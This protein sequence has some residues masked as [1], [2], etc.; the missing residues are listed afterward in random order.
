MNS[1]YTVG[2]VPLGLAV[3]CSVPTV[4]WAQNIPPQIPDIKP[5]DP[6]QDEQVPDFTPIPKVPIEVVPPDPPEQQLILPQT[7]IVERFEIV[8]NSV[9][10]TEEIL[11]VLQEFVGVSLTNEDLRA[12]ESKVGQLYADKGFITSFAYLRLADNQELDLDGAIVTLTVAEGTIEQI[13]VS[14]KRLNR[15]IKRRLKADVKGVVKEDELQ[16]SLRWLLNDPRIKTISVTVNPGSEYGLAILNADVTLENPINVAVGLNNFRSPSVGT[17]ERQLQFQHLNV[18]GLGDTFSLGYRNTDG[19]NAVRVGYTVPLNSNDGTLGIDYQFVDSSIIEEPFDVLD[20]DGQSNFVQ[21]T[22]RQPIYRKA[23]ADKI[24]EVAVGA[25]LSHEDSQLRS[26]LFSGP[27]SRGAE[28]DGSTRITS[29]RFFQEW[30]KRQRKSAFGLRSQ[31]SL[32]L[33]LAS[34]DNAQA[35]D[36]QYFKWQGG[37]RWSRKLPHGLIFVTR[38]DLQFS[39]RPLLASEQFSLGGQSTIRGYRQNALLSDNG[40]L[41]TIALEIPVLKGKAGRLTLYPF[42]DVGTVWNNSQ[43]LIPTPNTLASA[44]VGVRYQLSDRLRATVELGIPLIN[45]PERLNT[46]Q[47]QG[48]YLSL[49]WN[50]F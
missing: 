25:T 4:A 11:D 22:Y 32:G 27:I 24:E 35:P 34:T 44:G 20:I 21:L 45:R 2:L 6:R 28:A 8:G 17:F 36:G 40:F 1:I 9:I 31:F 50:A 48:I 49:V 16:S 18:F 3:I 41:A 42:F 23:T 39:D 29:L 19:S 7:L 33:D 38:A 12:V 43:S 46:L 14:S 26:D 13:N 30:S 37:A 15:Y 5:I 10:D 47:E